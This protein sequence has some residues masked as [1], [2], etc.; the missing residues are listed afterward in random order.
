MGNMGNPL[1]H[2]NK[3]RRTGRRRTVWLSIAVIVTLILLVAA[4][5]YR[6][7]LSRHEVYSIESTSEVTFGQN[8]NTLVIDNGKTTLL[9]LDADGRLIRSYEGGSDDAPF[10]YAA[11]AAQTEDGSI[12]VVDVKY[13]DRGMMLDWERVIRLNGK[14]CETVYEID[15]T[16]WSQGITPL[17]YGQI[18]ELQAYGDTVFFLLATDKAVELKQIGTDG[19]VSSVAS[20]P[21]GGVKQAVSYDASTGRIA[22][23]NRTGEILLYDLSGE[24][25]YQKADYGKM[26]FDISARSGEV[27]YPDLQEQVVRRFSVDDPE[28]DEVFAS[29]DELPFKLDVSADGKSVLVTNYAGFYRLEAGANGECLSVDYVDSAENPGFVF[30]ILVWAALV[31]GGLLALYLIFLLVRFLIPRIAKNETAMRAVLIV[32]AALAVAFIVSYSLLS[33]LLSNSTKA[34]ERQVDLFSQ[35]LMSKIDID[36]LKGIEGEENF[37]DKNYNKLKE[38]LGGPV[39]KSYDSGEYYYYVIY[40]ERNGYIC[41]VIDSEEVGPCWNPLYQSEEDGITYAEVLSTGKIISES[42]IS[43]YGSWSFRLTPIRDKL[44]NIIAVLEVGQ[45][46]TAVEQRQSELKREVIINTAIGTIVMAMLLIE[47]AFLI[48]FVQKRQSSPVL[49]DTEKVPVRTLMVQKNLQ[50]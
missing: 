34:S 29:F 41:A 32:L 1:V 18:N 16:A 22:V 48:G 4:F 46:L 10:Y 43:A 11:Y 47:L 28:A 50:R 2:E 44:G 42:E 17:Q 26:P 8:G 30:T 45:S 25:I 5:L 6:S 20:I 15:Y 9:V 27:Y 35:Y 7:L 12:Y 3:K 14:E 19:A 13:G 39:R 31:L 33:N 36:V 24:I 21:A 49:D 23:V 37:R 38:A 40:R